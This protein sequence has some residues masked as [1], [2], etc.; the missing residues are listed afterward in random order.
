MTAG[1]RMFRH[2]IGIDD[3]PHVVTLTHDP[4]AVAATGTRS[5]LA[6]VDGKAAGEEPV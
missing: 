5:A 4:V 1:R 3:Q 6:L 2:V